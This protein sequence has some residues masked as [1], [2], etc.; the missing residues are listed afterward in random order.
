LINFIFLKRPLFIPKNESA[1]VILEVFIHTFLI[2]NAFLFD[3]PSIIRSNRCFNYEVRSNFFNI[4]FNHNKPHFHCLKMSYLNWCL[5]IFFLPFSIVTKYL[6][7]VDL[8]FEFNCE[9]LHL[10]GFQTIHSFLIS[11]NIINEYN[12]DYNTIL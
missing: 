3:K 2:I 4:D 11:N 10:R 7:L 5:I 8:H 6:N 12:V 1:I 9:I